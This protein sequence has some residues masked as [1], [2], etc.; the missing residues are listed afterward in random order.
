VPQNKDL[1]RL[2]RARM[3]E[4]GEH[5]TQALTHVLGPADLQPLPA[6]WHL[7]GNRPADYEAGILPGITYGED[8]VARLRLRP[9][10]DKPTGFGALV[11]TI[12]APRYLGRRVR[13]SAMVRTSGVTDW[14]GLWLRVDGT[15]GT[16]VLDNMQERALRGTTDW[17]EAVI[18]LDV[19][20]EATRLLFG[21]L[22]DGAGAVDLARLRFEE[23]SEDTPTTTAVIMSPL[24]DEPQSLDFGAA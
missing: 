11:Q 20:E 23:A 7:T 6:P 14:A 12:A 18:V 24:P 22:L 8:R 9:S 1:K 4:T 2:V 3:A 13:Y 5:Y 17:T 21:A 16:L 15:N 10:V 19:A